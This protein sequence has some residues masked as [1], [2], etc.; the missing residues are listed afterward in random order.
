MGYAWDITIPSGTLRG[1]PKTQVLKLHPGI[2]TRVGVKFPAGCHGLV[3]VRI[4]RGGVANVFPLDTDGYATG[5]DD[6]AWSNYYYVFDDVPA[7]LRFEGWSPEC[8]YDHTVTVRVT[9]L[10]RFV[11]SML[12]LMELIGKLLNRMGVK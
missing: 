9:V 5:D 1:D 7:E 11:A 6:E 12:P 10:P 2:I 4:L 3:Y 8:T